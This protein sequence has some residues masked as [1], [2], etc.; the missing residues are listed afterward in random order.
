M[1]G[2]VERED[3]IAGVVGVAPEVKERL[4][5]YMADVC[6]GLVRSEQRR[7]AAVYARGLLEAG[8]RK[9]LEPMVARLGEDGDYES[10]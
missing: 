3:E 7:S 4:G 2:V 9:S 8:W 1:V 5:I 10:L 6:R